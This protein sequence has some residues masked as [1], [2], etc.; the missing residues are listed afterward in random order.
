MSRVLVLGASG[1]LG[2]HATA[3]LAAADAHVVPGPSRCRLDLATA[4]QRD[5]VALVRLVRPSAVVN[6][7]GR[8]SGTPQ[9]LERDNVE[10]TRR[11][12]AACTEAAPGVRFVHLGSLAEYGPGTG[13]P[14]HEEGPAEP[15]TG[16]GRS[17]LRATG[18]VLAAADEGRVDGVVLR[19]AN[20]VGAGQ[21]AAGL[22]GTVVRQLQE[23][24]GGDVVVGALDGRRDFVS[25]RDVGAAVAVAALAGPRGTGGLLLNVGTGRPQEVRDV[26]R[27]LLALSGTGATLVEQD[28]AGSERS[29]AVRDA[30]P[31]VARIAQVLGWRAVDGVE[32]ALRCVLD[33]AGLLA[34]A[35]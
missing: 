30:V 25:A 26:V 24:P 29:G 32:R 15:G 23:R 16:Y 28:R 17:K 2:R 13:E 14:F 5:L 22:I 8:V 21:P 9:E 31:D 18:A 4:S 20:P 12:L 6:A 1:F 34:R 7:T 27:A 19:V 10:L 11:L 3:A 35:S 33:G